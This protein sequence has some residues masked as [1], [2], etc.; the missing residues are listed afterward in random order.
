[1]LPASAV[2]VK[3]GVVTLVRLSALELPLSLAS[4]RLG[5]D[6][7]GG[8]VKSPISSLPLELLVVCPFAVACTVK[9]F[10]PAG[11]LDVVVSVSVVDTRLLVSFGEKLALTPAGSAEVTE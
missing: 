9:A 2:P 1:M 11:E 8:A 5:T 7:T 6:G 10:R 3:V 4:A